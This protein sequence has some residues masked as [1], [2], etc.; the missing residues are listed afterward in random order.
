MNLAL[1][2][3]GYLPRQLLEL[4]RDISKEAN[5]LGQKAYLVGGVVRDLLLGYPNFDLDLVIEGDA[6]VSSTSS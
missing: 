4:V 5:Q 6:V 3:E 2:I 1:Q